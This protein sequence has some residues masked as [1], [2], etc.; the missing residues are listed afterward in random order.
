MTDTG[1]IRIMIVDD[2]DA[3]RAGLTTVLSLEDD[4]DVVAEAR[5]GKQAFTVAV[6][7]K[8]DLVLMDLR[9]PVLDGVESTSLILE[10]LPKTRVL[11]LTTFSDDASIVDALRVGASG[12]ITKD[13]PRSAIIGA[14]RSVMAGQRTFAGDVGE[15]LVRALIKTTNTAESL[16]TSALRQRFPLLTAR[17]AD[18]LSQVAEGWSNPEIAADL[19][20]SIATVKSHINAIFSKLDVTTRAQAIARARA[21]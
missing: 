12:Y 5:D 10:S 17:E 21:I 11:V 14:I 15:V 8:P 6:E 9:M 16:S 3:Q 20:V 2:E 7:L 13:T 18:I 1:M 19:F 4:M